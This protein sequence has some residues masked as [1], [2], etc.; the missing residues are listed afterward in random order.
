MLKVGLIGAGFMGQMHA[1]CYE[2]LRD[3]DVL[4]CAVADVISIIMGF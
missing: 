1:A 4:V 2:A 3:A